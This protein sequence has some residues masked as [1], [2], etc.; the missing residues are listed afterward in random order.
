M[1]NLQ[2]FF[3]DLEFTRISKGM[4]VFQSISTLELLNEFNC[5]YL[6]HV[7]C[8]TELS[9]NLLLDE[10][11]FYHDPS[12]YRKL[13]GKLIFLTHTRPDLTFLVHHLSQFMAIPRIP[14]WQTAIHVL[15]YLNPY[16]R[17]TTEYFSF[18]CFRSIL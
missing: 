2:Y 8:P 16:T 4:I 1:G 15:R 17:H 9:S 6:S 5:K 12:Y 14:L 3:P 11:D 18:F 13:A 7:F 10:C